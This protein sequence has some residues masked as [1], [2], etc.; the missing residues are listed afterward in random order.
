MAVNLPNGGEISLII[1]PEIK[2][3]K[4]TSPGP[5]QPTSSESFLE[6]K[7]MSKVGLVKL[8][9]MVDREFAHF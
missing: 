1:N 2:Y 6:N 3:H 7:I 8:E 9:Y 5:F 4:P